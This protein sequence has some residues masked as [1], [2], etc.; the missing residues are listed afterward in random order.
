MRPNAPIQTTASMLGAVQRE[1]LEII[2]KCTRLFGGEVEL[3]RLVFSPPFKEV[4]LCKIPAGTHVKSIDIK[5]V[6]TPVASN[7]T[8]S[9]GLAW[10]NPRSAER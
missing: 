9:V 8:M 3:R 10:T 6:L 4:V 7:S 1:T 2:I 5:H